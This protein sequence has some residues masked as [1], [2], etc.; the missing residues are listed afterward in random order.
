MHAALNVVLQLHSL[1]RFVVLLAGLLALAVHVA[2]GVRG[3]PFAKVHRVSGSA[4]ASSL[5]LQ[6]TLGLVGIALGRY[7]PMLIGHLT[8]ALAAAVGVQV[9]ISKNRR[10]PTPS[11]RLP[12]VAIGA[13]LIVL[14]LGMAAIGRLPWTVT[15]LP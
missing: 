4:Y 5:H 13:S 1:F 6:A 3:Q 11:L 10:R 7:Y 2:S 14:W 8:L 12:T 9:A 15:H